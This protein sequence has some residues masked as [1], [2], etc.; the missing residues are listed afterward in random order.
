MSLFEEKIKLREEVF[1]SLYCITDIMLNEEKVE[2]LFFDCEIAYLDFLLNNKEKLDAL[3]SLAESALGFTRQF[4][5]DSI[6]NYENDRNIVFK[7]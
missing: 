7:E 5:E 3:R 4:S 6:R 1:D 2:E